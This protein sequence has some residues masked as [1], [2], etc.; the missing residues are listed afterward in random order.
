MKDLYQ[1]VI[2][3]PWW[4]YLL[5]MYL[6]KIGINA[7]KTRMVSLKKLFLMPLIF[8]LMSVHTL[9]EYFTMNSFAI[10]VLG[11]AMGIGILLGWLQVFRYSLKVDRQ[12]ALIQIPGTWSTLGVIVIIF[13][14]KYYFGYKLALDPTLAKEMNFA[15]SLLGVSGVCT[16]LFLGRL[17]CYLYRF[18]TLPSTML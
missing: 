10:S 15:I 17:G 1:I 5:A 6:I 14:A 4:V 9:I 8:I 7:T 18:K 3:T 16:G 13:T 2:N 12:R 11:F